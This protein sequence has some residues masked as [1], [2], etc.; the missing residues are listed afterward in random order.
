MK[1]SVAM[2]HGELSEEL[3]DL[4][5][6]RAQRLARFEAR[7]GGVTITFD[8][9]RDRKRAEVRA[10]VEGDSPVVARAGGPTHRTALDRALDRAI[11]QL[12]RQRERRRDLQREA[13]DIEVSDSELPASS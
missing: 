13:P 2:R 8:E 11:R 9:D 12:K 7:L 4:T 6:R 1:V 10:G 3:R 5:E